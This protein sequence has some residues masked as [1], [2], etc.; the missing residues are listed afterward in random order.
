MAESRRETA[1][2]AVRSAAGWAL[3]VVLFAVVLTL[4]AS[5][6]RLAPPAPLPASAPADQ[7]SAGRARQVLAELAGDLRPHPVGSAADFAVRARIVANL[8]A[9][10]YA[11]QVEPGFACQ[12]GDACAAVENVV[13]ELPGR[14][15]SEAV[16]LLAHY[17][18]VAAGP[19][20]S[21]DLSSVAAILEA[22]RILKAG[23]PLRNS[24]IFLLDEGE[25]AALLGAQAFAASSPEARTVRAVVN[26]DARGTSG[27]SLMF[28][29]SPDNGWLAPLYAASVRRP[30]LS[31]LFTVLYEMLPNDTDFSVLRRRASGFNFA[32]IGDQEHYHTPHDNLANLDLG[33]LQH[34]GDNALA[35][36]RAL[37]GADLS[38]PHRAGRAVFFDLL[39]FTT[40]WWPAPWSAGLAAA[41]LALLLLAAVRLRGKGLLTG[42]DLLR[43]IAAWPLA[44]VGTLVVAILFGLVLSLAGGLRVIWPA[45][46]FPTEATF[47]FLAATVAFAVISWVRRASFAGLWVGIWLWWGVLGLALALTLPGTCYLFVVPLL[48]AGVAALLLPDGEAGRAIATLVPAVFAGAIWF[49][50][51]A[52]VYE[53]LGAVLPIMA[54]IALLVAIALSPLLPLVAGAGAGWRIGLPAVAGLLTAV[55]AVG[56]VVLPP[57]SPISPRRLNLLYVDD[58]DTHRGRWAVPTSGPLPPPL[59]QAAEFDKKPQP[60]QPWSSF[61]P[62]Y[63]AAAPDL[64]LAPPELAVVEDVDVGGKRHLRLRLRSPRGAAIG[65][66]YIPGAA[67]VESLSVA[68]HEVPGSTV[69][70]EAVGLRTRRTAWR[71]LAILTLPPQGIEIEAVL[72]ARAPQSWTIVD[73]TSGLPPAGDALERARP[74]TTVQSQDGDVT[75]V[76]RKTQ[77]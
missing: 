33:S 65:V 31:S 32:F 2:P 27:R 41:G 26:L 25:E 29:T 77:I 6:A 36:V 48:A 72:A 8:R 63:T 49:P 64:R 22:A 43:G 75:I 69:A 28:E 71:T 67:E 9:S 68:G 3:P 39:G 5:A 62:V 1:G 4:V 47:W 23:P 61:Q 38:R 60:P 44:V 52:V 17:D 50:T 18:S 55:M 73:R 45:R 24:V 53:G 35:T 46:P 51:L 19:G 16:I 40:V 56:V 54:G 20:V 10:G 59:R 57:F 11:S 42:G 76:T 15:P 70:H 74:N 30:A 66:L 7:F 12:R 34:Q 13:A 21:D 58:A 14:E 37:A